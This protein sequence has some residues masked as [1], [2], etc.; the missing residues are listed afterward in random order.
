MASWRHICHESGQKYEVHEIRVMEGSSSL[1]GPP[2]LSDLARE[3]A[4][5][6]QGLEYV[7]QEKD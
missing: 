4:M 5:V 7:S 3:Q 2:L 6:N 1:C